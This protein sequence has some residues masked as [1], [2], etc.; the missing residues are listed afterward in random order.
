MRVLLI[1]DEEATIRQIRARLQTECQANVK[2]ARSRDTAIEILKG[3]ED[4]DLIVCDLR[5][6][7]RDG[8]LDVDQEHGLRVHDVARTEHPGTFTIFFSGFVELENVGARLSAGPS[9]DVFATGEEWPLV[10]A[11]LKSKQPEFLQWATKLSMRLREVNQINILQPNICLTNEFA[12]R[13]LRIYA[14]RLNGTEIVSESLGGLSGAKVL[15]VEILDGSQA[16]VGLVVAKVDLLVRI[17]DELV[18]YRRHVAPVLRVGTFAPLAGEV[19]HGCG[20]FGAAFYSLAANG[21]NDLFY[22]S[23]TDDAASQKAVSLLRK[24]HR[25][26]RGNTGSSNVSVG[27]VRSS[28]ISD[29]QLAP[30][31]DDLSPDRVEEA[32]AITISM[33]QSIQHGDLHGLNVLVDSEGGPLIIDYGNFA[34]HPVALDPV[35]LEMSF[36]FH[37]EHPELHGWPSIEQASRWF[38]LAEYVRGSHLKEVV[39]ACRQWAESD[40]SRPELAAIVYAHA[41]RQLKYEDT[42]KS[43][44]LAI[45]K[46]AMAELIG[47]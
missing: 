17:E 2:L 29:E 18:R 46:A 26:W 19:L 27:T 8:S 25:Q 12:W 40:T 44:A 42:N 30:W 41:V 38:D 31:R 9:L 43:L 14:K 13:T 32:E 35:T 37:A 10:D 6:P 45:A 16:S 11:L 36:V 23:I 21:Y 4:F 22:L 34:R 1:E 33:K 47:E 39:G 3:N 24:S 15:R 20:R 5:I 7:T 28:C